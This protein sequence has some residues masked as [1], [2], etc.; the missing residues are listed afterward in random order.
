MSITA[1]SAWLVRI[2]WMWLNWVDASG[3]IPSRNPH[4]YSAGL[5]LFIA[6]P[7][8]TFPHAVRPSWHTLSVMGVRML[9]RCW[10]LF[11]L[12][13]CGC[14]FSNPG[15]L[16]Q[17]LRLFMFSQTDSRMLTSGLRTIC[18]TTLCFSFDLNV[19]VYCHAT[20]GIL[21]KSDASLLALRNKHKSKH[22]RTRMLIT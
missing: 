8:P 12:W 2:P 17:H 16:P 18:C 9:A 19:W 11:L 10:S 7:S 5:C 6:T 4:H 21:D 20:E 13:T 14:C 3:F 22:K 15:K 1:L